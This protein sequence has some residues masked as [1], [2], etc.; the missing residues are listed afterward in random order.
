MSEVINLIGVD[1]G[2]TNIRAGKIVDQKIIQ[3][4][5]EDTFAS[6]TESE[7]LN[8]LFAAVD[9]CLDSNTKSIGIGVPSIVDV[10]KGIVYDVVNIPSWKTVPLKDILE[11]RYNVPV[12]VNNDANCFAMGE[13]YFG[14][15]KSCKNIVGLTLGTGMGTGLIFNG[16]LYEG[17]NCCAGEFGNIPY[18]NRNFERYCSGEFFSEQKST[19]ADIAYNKALAGDP[20][21]LQLFSEFGFHLGQAV[22]S[23]L[24]A[25]DPEMIIM[26]GSLTKAYD[27]FKADMLDAISDFAYQ[28]VLSPE[29][30]GGPWGY[31]NLKEILA[32][33][34]HEEYQDTKEWL[35]LDDNDEW[36]ANYFEPEEV[37][38]ILKGFK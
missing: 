25:Y 17:R 36:D 5:K 24:Y 38:K 35:G 30:C 31:E 11:T 26:G 27:F 2:G 7:V 34:K 3:I 29:D 28:N 1:L 20:L 37:N 33:P 32:D 8:Q 4:A 23:I 13:K 10:E 22:K 9:P 16:K 18:L 21:A 12:Y 19:S 6:G 14:K 15:A